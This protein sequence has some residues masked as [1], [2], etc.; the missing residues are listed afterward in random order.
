MSLSVG[1]SLSN[2][3]GLQLARELIRPQLPHDIH[4]YVLEGVCKAVD[5]IHVLAV[6]PTGGGKTGY[7]FGYILLLKALEKMSPPC[8]QLKRKFPQNPAMVIVFPTKGLEEEMEKKFLS[9]K[10]SAIAINEDTLAFARKS[11][12]NLWQECV[13]DATVIL[14][15]P[16]LLSSQPFNRLLQNRVFTLR[17]CLLGIDEV[18]LVQDWGDPSFRDAFRHIALVHARMPRGTIII[19]LTATLLAGQE[20][21]E[22]LKTLGFTPGTF[23]FQ[24]HSNI[25]RDV[26]DIYRVLRH[27]LSGWTFPDL[28]W[29]IEGNRK[30]LIYCPNFALCFRLRIYYYYK[31]PHKLVRIYNSLCFSNYN[32]DTRRLFVEDPN[33]Q[34][35]VATDALVVGIDF[36]NVEDVIDLDCRH[37]NH[38]KQRK[39]RAGRPGGE[40]RN[41]R[42]ITYV[43]K[44]TL[45]K[46]KRM[47]VKWP[48][49]DGGKHV[50]QGL[51]IGEARLLVAPCYPACEDTLYD[52]PIADMHLQWFSLPTRTSI[53]CSSMYCSNSTF[54]PYGLRLTEKMT[55]VGTIRL[56][57]FRHLLWEEL[58]DEVDF[59]PPLAFLPNAHIK[60]ILDNFARIKLPADLSPYINDLHLLSVHEARLFSVVTELR[61]TF[62]SMQAPPGRKKQARHVSEPDLFPL[63][64]IAPISTPPTSLPLILGPTSTNLDTQTYDNFWTSFCRPVTVIPVT[65]PSTSSLYLPLGRAKRPYVEDTPSGDPLSPRKLR[66]SKVCSFLFEIL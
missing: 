6:A 26:Q 9:L 23:F 59:L 44:A 16:E 46:A 5:G 66:S 21:T 22:L 15:S 64:D 27:G 12:R 31:A 41:P 60:N 20:T 51:H 32:A 18:H 58:H 35:I 36:P 48:S 29:V 45:D 54:H 28:D 24:R 34:V 55:K 42:G 57:Q 39:G 52:N 63:L 1:I 40:V 7:F 25:R 3:E 10:I 53:A 33:L 8:A 4:D 14:L 49:H 17:L 43:T 47:V 2:P 37:P 30:T 38:G 65:T 13:E 56:Q 61:D 50:E 11:N 19:G 62:S